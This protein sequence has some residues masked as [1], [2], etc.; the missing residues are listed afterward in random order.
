[1][2]KEIKFKNLI[3]YFKSP[4][5]SPTNFIGFRGP[6]SVYNIIKN[7]NTSIKK[8]EE[9]QEQLKSKLSEIV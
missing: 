2:N 6:L 9:E 5:F 4:N 1:M 8:L 3:Y 7:G